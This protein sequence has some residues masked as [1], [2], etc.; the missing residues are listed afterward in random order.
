MGRNNLT[1]DNEPKYNWNT[2]SKDVPDSELTPKERKEFRK[3]KIG[4]SF[5]GGAIFIILILAIIVAVW[6]MADSQSNRQIYG[7]M[8]CKESF[9]VNWNYQNTFSTYTAASTFID[10]CVLNNHRIPLTTMGFGSKW[11]FTIV[12]MDI[13]RSR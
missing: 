5:L 4:F 13:P 9:G 2:P 8:F 6:S 10:Y 11:E 7:D 1:Y 3:M 12:D